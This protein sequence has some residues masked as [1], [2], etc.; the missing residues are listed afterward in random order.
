[1]EISL[2]Q[3]STWLRTIIQVALIPFA[4]YV[5]HSLE[6]LNNQS[7]LMAYQLNSQIATLIQ[8]HE[9]RIRILEHRTP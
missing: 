5:V 4:V 9:Q 2:T 7:T 6:T 8:D 1:M 3:I